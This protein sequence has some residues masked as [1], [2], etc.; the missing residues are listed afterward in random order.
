MKRWY[1]LCIYVVV[2][3]G[4]NMLQKLWK[5]TLITLFVASLVMALQPDLRNSVRSAV[6][7]DSR[8]VVSSV[9]SD[10]LHNGTMFSIEK[11]KT[12]AGLFLEISQPQDDGA[13]R[14]VEKI[15]MKDQSD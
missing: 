15:E 1:A 10:L 6:L 13:Q 12:R 4:G 11:V 2:R 14:L 8:T 7:K 9:T 3:L 5:S